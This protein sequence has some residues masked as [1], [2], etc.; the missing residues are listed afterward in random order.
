MI[1]KKGVSK[2]N[3][4]QE[5]FSGKE[6]SLQ[7]LYLQAFTGF[8]GDRGF[9]PLTSTMYIGARQTKTI[10]NKNL[11]PRH[12][13]SCN[14]RVTKILSK[15]MNNNQQKQLPERVHFTRQEAVSA[16]HEKQSGHKRYHS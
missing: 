14:S 12:D 2:N 7:T 16:L 9:E 8:M 3:E 6:K 15:T 11:G 1:T 10:F 5:G 13:F 4:K